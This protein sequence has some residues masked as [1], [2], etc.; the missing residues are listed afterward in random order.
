MCVCVCCVLEGHPENHTQSPKYPNL[1][2]K[3][4]LVSS[5]TYKWKS[6]VLPSRELVGNFLLKHGHQGSQKP[7]QEAGQRQ[8]QTALL[9]SGLLLGVWGGG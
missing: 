9:N 8:T 6:L 7:S 1:N 3:I 4:V 5:E 2:W